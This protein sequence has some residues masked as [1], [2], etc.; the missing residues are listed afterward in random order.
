MF[1]GAICI[2]LPALALAAAVFASP[3]A[4]PRASNGAGAPPLISA[5]RFASEAMATAQA[6][7]RYKKQGNSC[8]WDGNDS[9]PNQCT[10][11]TSGRF[12][13]AGDSC[14]WD[15]AERGDDQ[16]TPSK[17]RF[18]KDGDRCQWDANDSGPNQCNPRSAR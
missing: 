6:K 1:H 13:K 8:V 2:G 14:V 17:G 4:D 3:V 10:P 18:K 16:C 11:T 12:K 7:G 15:A 9:G 5:S